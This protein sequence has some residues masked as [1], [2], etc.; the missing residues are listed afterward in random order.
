MYKNHLGRTGFEDVK[1]SGRTAEAWDCEKLEKAIGE[2]AASV[3]VDDPGLKGLC[4]E[5]EAWHHEEG[6]WEAISEAQLQQKIAVYWRCQY[7]GMTT[8]SNSSSGE[9]ST[10]AYSATEGRAGD[11]TQVLW[12][13]LEYHV[14]IPDIE[15]RSYKVGH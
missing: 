13:G 8:K 4:K 2:G 7:H 9:E 1:A 5:S 3:A 14:W 6:L 12:R 15:T 11:V 10:R